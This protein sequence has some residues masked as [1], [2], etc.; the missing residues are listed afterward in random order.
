MF[1]SKKPA[2][3]T[4]LPPEVT[5]SEWQKNKKETR[6]KYGNKTS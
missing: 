4:V 2:A 1:W 6:I 3:G 5:Y